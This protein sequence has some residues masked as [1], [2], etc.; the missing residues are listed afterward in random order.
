MNQ[1]YGKR[2]IDLVLCVPGLILLSPALLLLAGLV[3]LQLGFPVLFRQ[4][5]PGQWGQSFTLLNF[6]P[7]ER[8]AALRVTYSPM[9]NA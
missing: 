2:L 6:G 3:G 5:R 8:F 9:P 1:R 4:P 7:C